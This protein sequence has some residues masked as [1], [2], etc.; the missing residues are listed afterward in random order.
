[1]SSFSWEGKSRYYDRNKMFILFSCIVYNLKCIPVSSGM[2]VHISYLA[3]P[4]LCIGYYPLCISCHVL[5][6]NLLLCPRHSK[7]GGGALS[8][9]PLRSITFE[10]LH[11]FNSNLVC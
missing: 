9:T 4:I 2:I 1:M 8:V 6:I 5:H 7:N 11:R 10:R 3:F